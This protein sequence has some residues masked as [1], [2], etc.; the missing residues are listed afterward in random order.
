MPGPSYT[1]PIR[2]RLYDLDIRDEVSC[3]TL[4]RY[5]EE[6]A[7][8]ASS[9]LGFTLDWYNARGQFWVLRTMRL[10]RSNAARYEDELE[11]RT[12]VSAMTRV[13]ADRNYLVRRVRDG[14]VLARATANWVYLDRKNMHPARIA[15]EIIA[16]FSNPDP[17]PLA[18]RKDSKSMARVQSPIR[19]ETGRRAF[20]FEAD[21]A[22]HTNNAVY[23][24][25]LEEAVRETLSACGYHVPVDSGP[26]LWFHRHWLE[27]LNAARPGD[28]LEIMTQLAGRGKTAG[29]WRQEIRRAGSHEIV[30]RAESAT[31]WVDNRDRPVR[32]PEL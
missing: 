28:D 23:V 32:W 11:I 31:F 16:L 5:F 25:W 19:G 4:F 12:W 7:M 8:Q 15:P 21:S 13:R 2:V 29:L 27:Y 17:P 26:S 18:P 22:K 14:R 30:V 24:A 10:E 6:T 9:R 3:A 20:Y 1:L